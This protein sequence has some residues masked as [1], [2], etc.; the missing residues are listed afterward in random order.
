MF[1]RFGVIYLVALRP[2]SICLLIFNWPEH[3][4][5]ATTIFM[6]GNKLRKTH[7]YFIFQQM[8]SIMVISCRSLMILTSL[9]SGLWLHFTKEKLFLFW[10]FGCKENLDFNTFLKMLLL[11]VA[12]GSSEV[13]LHKHLLSSYDKTVRWALILIYHWVKIQF[14]MIISGHQSITISHF[15]SILVSPWLRL[16]T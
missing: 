1:R 5:C 8:H 15:K 14:N 12:L 4:P 13:N 7:R 16:L 3:C 11:K 6:A 10:L 9:S 2:P